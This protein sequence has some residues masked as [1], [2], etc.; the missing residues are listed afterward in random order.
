MYLTGCVDVAENV[1]VTPRHTTSQ[2]ISQSWAD[3]TLLTQLDN[4]LPVHLGHLL[5]IWTWN[6]KHKNT[7]LKTAVIDLRPPTPLKV[8]MIILQ[9]ILS[10]PP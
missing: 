8:I 5:E 10:S 9:I 1:D 4:I 6:F 2:C 7:F 3:F